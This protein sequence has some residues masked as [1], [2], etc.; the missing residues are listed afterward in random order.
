MKKHVEYSTRGYSECWFDPNVII[1]I[2]N[3]VN[4]NCWCGVFKNKIK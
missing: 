2:I 3:L 4:P 1:V